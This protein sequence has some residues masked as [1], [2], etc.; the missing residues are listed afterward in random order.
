MQALSID[1]FNNYIHNNK[2]YSNN[3][4][5]VTC[6]LCDLGC[7]EK[8]IKKNMHTKNKKS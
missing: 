1:L 4:S 2:H 7:N 6:N 8:H 3:H 5:K